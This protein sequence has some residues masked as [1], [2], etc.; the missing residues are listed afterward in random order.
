MVVVPGSGDLRTK[1]LFGNIQLH[2]EWRMP[3]EIQGRGQNRGNSGVFL[4][5]LYELQILDSYQNE[6]YV[7]GQAASIYKQHPPLVNASRPPGEWQTFDVVFI[8]PQFSTRG[9]LVS[10]ARMTVFHNGVLVHHDAGLR[11][12]TVFRGEP[13]YGAHTNELP[14]QLQDHR[15]VVA[16]RNIWVRKIA[17]MK[18]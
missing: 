12:A 17:P 2:L 3:A 4:M 9:N 1:Q 6:T 18:P 14:L 5:G 10:P 15:H 7:N 13:Q 16:F 8:A 11:G